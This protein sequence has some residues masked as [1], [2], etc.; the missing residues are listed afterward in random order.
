MTPQECS[1]WLERLGLSATE[2]GELLNLSDPHRA[3]TRML[4]AGPGNKPPSPPTTAL[5][6]AYEAIAT[7]LVCLRTG[8]P[9]DARHALDQ[10]ITGALKRTIRERAPGVEAIGRD[11]AA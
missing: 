5:M 7:A 4:Q 9:D 11:S 2:G 10:I 3:M 6:E 1:Q 8:R